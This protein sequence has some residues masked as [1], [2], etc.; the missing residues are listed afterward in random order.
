MDKKWRLSITIARKF[1]EP[2]FISFWLTF[3]CRYVAD[4][5]R[6]CIHKNGEESV[7][8]PE[9]WGGDYSMMNYLSRVYETKSFGNPVDPTMETK[10]TACESCKNVADDTGSQILLQ[11]LPA[12]V[13]SFEEDIA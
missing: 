4:M 13:G 8:I 7:L 1:N 3:G 2:N 6:D 10:I 5:I 11:P 9:V 12:I